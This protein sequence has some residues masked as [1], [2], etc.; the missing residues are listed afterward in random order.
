[1]ATAMPMAMP[2]Y[3]GVVRLLLGGGFD[4]SGVE[5]G[6]LSTGDGVLLAVVAVAEVLELDGMILV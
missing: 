6:L 4:A 3:A 2:T 5:E 1:M